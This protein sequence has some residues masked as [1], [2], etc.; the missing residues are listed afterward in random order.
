MSRSGGRAPRRPLLLSAAPAAARPRCSSSASCA[1]VREDGVA[2]AR[3]L[4]ITF[5]ERAAGELRER[6]RD[7]SARARRA[8]ARH[9]TPR[10]PSSAPST[11]SAR[12]CCAPT[13]C[14]RA[15]T[16]TSRSSTRGSPGGCERPSTTALADFLARGARARGR[17]RRGLRRR[18]LRSMI[19]GVTRSCAAGVSARRGCRVRERRRRP[20]A[21]TRAR[22]ARRVRRCSTSCWSA[23]PR[24][25]RGSSTRA[26]RSTSTISSCAPAPARRRRGVRAAWSERFEL[27]MVD[28]FQDTNPRQLGI[29]ARSSATTCSP[30]ATSSSRSTA[31]ATPT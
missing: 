18:P 2:P 8:R 17:S 29:L 25:T 12:G 9:A 5:T 7:A 24:P 3:I 26:R 22:R 6:V 21:R 10:P 20:R 13:R 16:R 31:S 4:A 14:R 23:S 11:A 19:E 1:A 27:L 28:E 15:S 30:S